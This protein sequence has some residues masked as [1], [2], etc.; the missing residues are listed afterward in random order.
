MIALPR[1]DYTDRFALASRAD[2]T[3]ERWARAMFG[4]VPNAGEILVWRVI[5]GLR[6]HRGPSPST[7]AGWRI[8]ERGDNWIRLEAESWFLAANLVVRAVSDEVSL[9]TAVHYKGALG[10]VVWTPCS[11]VHRRLV[12][13]VL[14]RGA[15]RIGVSARRAGTG[16]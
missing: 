9:T 10:R 6:L 12:P 16:A 7:V 4:D 11:A 5:L 13:R 1:V 8:A 14:R 2:A 15:D 3:P